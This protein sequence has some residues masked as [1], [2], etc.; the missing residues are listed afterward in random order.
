M[1]R[2]RLCTLKRRVRLSRGLPRSAPATLHL[3]DPGFYICLSVRESFSTRRELRNTQGLPI[4]DSVNSLRGSLFAGLLASDLS[5]IDPTRRIANG[6]RCNLTPPTRHWHLR[7]C[8]RAFLA[9]PWATGRCP[10][11]WEAPQLEARLRSLG[12]PLRPTQARMTPKTRRKFAQEHGHTSSYPG[13]R[14]TTRDTAESQI[15]TE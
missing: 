10:C 14:K 8:A 4:H 1:R 15:R 11:A 12:P 3:Q 13:R 2:I 6:L 5:T 9:S 7:L